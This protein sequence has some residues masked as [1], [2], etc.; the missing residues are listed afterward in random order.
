MT[1]VNNIQ[2]SSSPFYEQGDGNS[3]M[4]Q[5]AGAY[6]KELRRAR[7]LSQ[8]DLAEMV[9]VGRGTIERLEAGDDRVGVGTVLHVFRVL[10]AS[11]WHFYELA[12]LPARTLAD[13]RQRRGVVQGIATYIATLAE[14]K[15]I[16]HAVLSE[17]TDASPTEREWLTKD[18]DSVS[19][20]TW[21]LALHYLDVPLAD[22]TPLFQAT[23]EHAAIGRQLA[24]AHGTF[25]RYRE[26][27]HS[28]E[29]G[30]RQSLPSL[31]S[32]IY[33]LSGLLRFDYN[34]PTVLKHELTHIEADLKRYRSFLILA[35]GY[36]K[37]EP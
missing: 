36:I 24:E 31:D 14:R 11:P 13:I 37:A 32:V 26:Q 27:T 19:E 28:L 21:L 9:N 8:N 23:A 30:D 35:V 10:G 17:V 25:A 7:D 4:M 3:A 34:L 1:S 5:K 33:R 15:Q 16:P 2:I 12:V 22:L 6:L 18:V 20:I 29:H